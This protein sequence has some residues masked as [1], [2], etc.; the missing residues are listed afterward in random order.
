LEHTGH[1][2]HILGV[3][4]HAGA[5]TRAAPS[6]TLETRSD[7]CD[8]YILGHAGKNLVERQFDDV[9][10]V[11]AYAARL[12]STAEHLFE[13]VTHVRSLWRPLVVPLTLFGIGKYFVRLIN[14]FEFFGVPGL[15]IRVVF[16]GEFAVRLF[17]FVGRCVPFDAQRLIVVRHHTYFC[18]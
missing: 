6:E 11:A 17:D 10:V 13:N 8:F 15:F 18:A 16:H 14:F 4:R 3:V 7:G 9:L 12:T 2:S 1:E 5:I